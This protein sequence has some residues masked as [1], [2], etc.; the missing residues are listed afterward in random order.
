MR[1]IDLKRWKF[2]YG[3]LDMHTNARG[4]SVELHSVCAEPKTTYALTHSPHY[5]A[6]LGYMKG[7]DGGNGAGFYINDKSH[8]AHSSNFRWDEERWAWVFQFLLI[9]DHALI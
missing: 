9:E 3:G 8:I 6:F 5:D 4:F 2:R 1:T 7:E